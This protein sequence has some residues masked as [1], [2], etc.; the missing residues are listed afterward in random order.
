MQNTEQ[1][2]RLKRLEHFLMYVCTRVTVPHR[3]RT[4][5]LGMSINCYITPIGITR[6]HYSSLLLHS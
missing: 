5:P 4:V 6:S 3:V 1:G 2:P